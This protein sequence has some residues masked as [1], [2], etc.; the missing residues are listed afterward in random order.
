MKVADLHIYN[1]LFNLESTTPLKKATT[2]STVCKVLNK[3]PTSKK[4]L[5]E[6][7]EWL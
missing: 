5:S 1:K 2:I 3:K 6:I 7:R 4:C